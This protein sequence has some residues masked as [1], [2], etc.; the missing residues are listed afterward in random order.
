MTTP[1]PHAYADWKAPREDGQILIWP[2]PATLLAQTLANHKRLSQADHVLVQNVPLAELR[3]RQRQWIHHDDARPLIAD[4]H[5]TELH[6]PGVWVKRVVAH[7]A[8][9]RLGGAAAHF[10]VDTDAPK[11]LQLRWI[12]GAEPVTDDPDVTKA[13]WTG[14][15]DAPSPAHVEHLRRKIA[16]ARFVEA[17]AVDEFL[18]SLRRLAIE[19]PTLPAALTNA[20]HELDWSLGLRHHALLASPLWESEPYLVFVHHV[21]ARAG[22][23]A[24]D[25]N[26]AL[27]AYRAEQGVRSAT[28][29]MPD[30]HARE[31][32][33]ELPFWLDDL[34]RGGRLRPSAVERD[35]G[36]VLSAPGG[37]EIEFDRSADGFEAASE[38]S[39]FLRRNQLRL[40]PRALTL[41]LFLRLCVV[42]QFVHGIGGGRYDQVTD[43]IIGTHFGVEPPHF[44]VVTATMYLPEAVGRS[45]VCVPCVAHEGHRLRHSL[46][47]Q[48]KRELVAQIEAAPRKSPQRYAAFAAMHREL[49]SAAQDHPALRQWEQRLR[50]T[51]SQEAEEAAIFDRELFYALQP[52]HRLEQ[53]VARFQK[54]LDAA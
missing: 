7:Q 22:R 53:M 6:H 23:F 15:L 34:S 18:A 39:R 47:G 5:Q 41:T 45:R 27:A 3:R 43:R 33:V 14:L 24:V 10:A 54:Q 50:E 13:E 19:Q 8:A 11:H 9:S 20:L 28:R 44:A 17:P 51:V 40:S 30:L 35:N 4:G 1:A 36:Y 29:P 37:E 42:D 49:T 21:I 12:G 2:A 16:E 31:G 38:L 26:A 46:L 32:S 25:Y 52:R 48:R